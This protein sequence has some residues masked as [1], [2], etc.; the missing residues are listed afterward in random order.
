MFLIGVAFSLESMRRTFVGGSSLSLF[1][2]KE[3]GL[4][5][6]AKPTLNYLRRYLEIEEEMLERLPDFMECLFPPFT[7]YHYSAVTFLE[8]VDILAEMQRPPTCEFYWE[9]GAQS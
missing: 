6:Q 9:K 2:I 5:Q 3:F 7:D 4:E 8:I 1:I